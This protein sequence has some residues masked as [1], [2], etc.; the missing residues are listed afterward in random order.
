MERAWQGWREIGI[1]VSAPGLPLESQTVQGWERRADGECQAPLR[2]R[3]G[4]GDG[5]R[6]ELCRLGLSSLP[7]GCLGR[8]SREWH[9]SRR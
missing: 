7:W 3:Q 4:E 8:H 9:C 2:E 6:P 1:C 5:S